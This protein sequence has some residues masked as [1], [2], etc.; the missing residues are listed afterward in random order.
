VKARHF[1][2]ALR[3]FYEEQSRK[4]LDRAVRLT[5]AEK[6][7]TEPDVLALNTDQWALEY[8]TIHHVQPLIEALDDD[9]SGFV[10][11]AEVNDFTTSRPA[12]WSYVALGYSLFVGLIIL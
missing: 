11:I 5:Q 4:S 6:Q 1:V 2:M 9:V 10:T 7:L 8:I 12:N 3:D